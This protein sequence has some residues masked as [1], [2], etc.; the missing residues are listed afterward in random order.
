MTRS[1][2]IVV[3]LSFTAMLTVSGWIV[4]S[5]LSKHG[6]PPVMPLWAHGLSLAFIL[7][8]ILSRTVK[9]QWGA[10]ALAIPVSFGAALRMSLGGDLAS[11]LTPARSGAEPARFLVLAETRMSAAHILLVLFVEL[12]MELTTLIVAAVSLWF[13]FR[14]SAAVLG[15]ITTI[16]ATYAAFFFA[17]GFAGLFL[18]QRNASGPPPQ[19][20][21]SVGLHAGHWRG[22]QRALRHL[23]VSVRAMRSAKPGW[24][25]AAFCASLVHMASR[26]AILPA[27]VWSINRAVPLSGLVLWPLILIYGGS[28]APAPGGGGTI[29]FGF[30]RAFDGTLAPTLLAASMLWW[31]FYTYYLYIV[32]GALAGGSTVLRALRPAE[33]RAAK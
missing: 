32:L 29:E 6:R 3:V 25:I 31:R 11:C 8:E 14:G 4:W 7:L 27:V 10:R 2:W 30:Q 21:R 19:W 12:L 26:L 1:R 28:M 15:F 17:V 33:R 22:I 23:R 24:L 5:A 16:I 13:I 18:A 9:V 20:V